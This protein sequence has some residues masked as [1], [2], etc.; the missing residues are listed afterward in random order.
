MELLERVQMQRKSKRFA[1]GDMTNKAVGTILW[2]AA[3][4][5]VILQGKVIQQLRSQGARQSSALTDKDEVPQYLSKAKSGPGEGSQKGFLN[6]A[7]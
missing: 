1:W 3:Q 2:G 5:G 6:N 7:T 4:A